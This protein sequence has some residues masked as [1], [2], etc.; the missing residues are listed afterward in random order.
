VSLDAGMAGL[1]KEEA[2]VARLRVER[3][4]SFAVKASGLV[5]EA[6]AIVEQIETGQGIDGAAQALA[7]AAALLSNWEPR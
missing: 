7:E 6:M 2:R 1:R 3:D 5:R 4:K